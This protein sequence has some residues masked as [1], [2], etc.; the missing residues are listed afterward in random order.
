MKKFIRF[1]TSGTLLIFLFLLIEVLVVLFFDFELDTVVLLLFAIRNPEIINALQIVEYVVTGIRILFV[2]IAIF[3]FFRIINKWEDPEFKIPWLVFLFIFPVV[4]VTFYLIFADH[5]LPHKE[6]RIMKSYYENVESRFEITEKN[7]QV[8]LDELDNAVG[9]F[10]YIANTAKVGIHKNNQVTYYK[11]GEAFFPA[12]IEG[13]KKAKEFIFIEFFIITDGKEW[14]AVKDILIQKAQEGVDVRVIYDD[15]GCGGTISSFTPQRLRKY[16]IKCYKFHP[17][18]PILSGVFNNRDHRKIVI[19]DHQMAFTGGINLADE[20]ANEIE[21]FGYWKDTMVKIEG[22]AIDNLI[23]T[24]LANYG[25]ASKTKPLKQIKKDLTEN[26]YDALK[27]L[28]HSKTLKKSAILLKKTSDIDHIVYTNDIAVIAAP[29]LSKTPHEIA[30]ELVELIDK[31]DIEKTKV[32]SSGIISFYIKDDFYRFLNHKYQTYSDPGYVMPFGDGP[33]GIDDALIGEQN[34][35]NILKY[36]KRKVYISTPYLIPTYQL[37]DAMINAS[38]RGV[39]VNLIVP[40][41]PDKKLVYLMAKGNFKPLLKAGVRIYKY[42]PGFNHMKSMLVDDELAF[43]GT[44]NFDFRSLVH[45]FECGTVLYKNN[46]IKDIKDDFEE[47]LSVSEEVPS[48]YK[49]NVWGRMVCGII[50]LIA[51]LL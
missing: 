46:C 8:L 38:L 3:L 17:F 19:V 13:L 36:A 48:T 45:H 18:R 50:K 43:V 34:Y 28:K 26:I 23:S 25:I 11:N 29:Y 24:F 5:G 30:N 42:K 1:L 47:M 4:T 21:R 37:M 6:K 14:T 35:V 15:M 39:E 51:P 2:I 9:T 31:T 41:I 33:G 22:S 7:N 12:M 20:Y 49:L 27:E 44:I 16:G 40:G 10:K 32:S